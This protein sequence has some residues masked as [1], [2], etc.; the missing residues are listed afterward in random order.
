[1]TAASVSVASPISLTR[2]GEVR[3]V[4]GKSQILCSLN[5]FASKRNVPDAY[6]LLEPDAY[7][8]GAW[9]DTENIYLYEIESPQKMRKPKPRMCDKLVRPERLFA[10]RAHPFGVALRAIAIAATRR[11]RRTPLLSVGNSN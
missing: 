2:Q 1:L 9:L 3:S 7:K 10:L 11:C 8:P 4:D 5:E 6:F